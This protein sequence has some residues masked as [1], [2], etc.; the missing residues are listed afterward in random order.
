MYL[1]T[2][3]TGLLG[4]A[5]M[6]HFGKRA[7]GFSKDALDITDE[8]NVAAKVFAMKPTAVINCAGFTNVDAAEKQVKEAYRINGLGPKIL[9]EACKR[10]NIPLIHISTDFVFDGKADKP[11]DEQNTQGLTPCNV[12]GFSKL[13]GE[14][15]IQ[16]VFED[17]YI[18]R[19]SWLFGLGADNVISRIV[20]GNVTQAANDLV[21]SPTNASL[22]AASVDN[23]MSMQAKRGIYNVTCS[24]QAPSYFELAL[25]VKGLLGKEYSTLKPISVKD[26]PLPAKRPAYTALKCSKIDNAISCT[27]PYWKLAVKWYMEKWL[28]CGV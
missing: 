27:R 3:A 24:G 22:V 20:D 5:M 15:A 13:S 18:I 11:Y 1:V 26:I 4:K 7:I 14:K 2:G 9:A 10:N 21:K 12:Y 25:Y 19:T 17:Y 23:L 8:H 6:E 16:S 28:T